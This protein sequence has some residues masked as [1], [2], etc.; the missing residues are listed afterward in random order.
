MRS[1]FSKSISKVLLMVVALSVM[2]FIGK[3]NATIPDDYIANYE[4][5]ADYNKIL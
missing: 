1:L 5:T 4:I 2:F 3:I